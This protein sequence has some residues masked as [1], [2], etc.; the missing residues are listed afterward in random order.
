MWALGDVALTI[1]SLGGGP[2]VP[3]LADAF[4]LASSRSRTWRWCCC[5]G[6]SRASSPGQVAR[7][8]RR[9]PRRGRGLRRVRVPQHRA[10]RRR[11]ARRRWRPTWPTRSA[12]CCCWPGGRR[13]RAALGPRA[14][15]GCSSPRDL[16]QRHR[17]HVQPLCSSA[18]PRGDRRRRRRLA[19]R[20][21]ADVDGGVAAPGRSDPLAPP[22]RAGLRA[23]RA[24]APLSGW[25]CCSSAAA[26][27]RAG[28]GGS[29]D[30]DAPGGRHPPRAVGARPADADRGAPP[31][32]HHRR[33]HRA[34]QPPP[35]SGARHVLRRPRERRDR[36]PRPGLPV[37]RPQPLQGD[38]RLLRPPGRR[39]APAPARPAA[40]DLPAASPTCWSGSAAT[41][42]P[43]S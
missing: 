30:G 2:A 39:R 23:A 43:S 4:Y 20:D 5:C 15:R 11:A 16:A 7:R 10:R 42:S 33:A 18:S 40:D 27:D 24:S 38:Q 14:A 12:T 37:R 9:R 13:H 32:G 28:R 26:R 19:D 17:R 21:R 41:S 6:G 3:S 22:G 29:G 34:R 8:R 31:P 35:P 36:C 1:E 25:R